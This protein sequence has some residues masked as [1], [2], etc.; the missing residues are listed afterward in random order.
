MSTN[1]KH[2][3][4]LLRQQE[5]YKKDVLEL[6]NIQ[7]PKVAFHYNC[8][9]GIVSAS[10]FKAIFSQLELVFIPLDYSIINDPE[11]L[12]LL[13]KTDWYA[14]L[15]LTPFNTNKLEL[16]VDHHISNIGKC[17]NANSIIF[18]SG[19]PSAAYLLSLMYGAKL[20]NHLLELARITEITDTASYAIPSPID[21]NDDFSSYSWDDKVWLLADV[22]KTIF[23]I[24]EHRNLIN[25]LVEYGLFGVW[26]E[27]FLSKVKDLRNERKRSMDIV[28]QTEIKDF[29]ILIDSPHNYDLHFIGSQLMYK[30]VKGSAY[31]SV[32]PDNVKISLRL[33]KTLSDEEID[34]YRVDELAKTLN[35]GGHKGASGGQMVSLDETIE[36]IHSWAKI[37][38]FSVIIVDLREN[39]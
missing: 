28:N 5:T 26:N 14:I 15:D 3:E 2:L 1:T 32:Y 10:L 29:I 7:Q 13:S 38:N 24:E 9:D 30:G 17:I 35:G 23:T 33:S 25:L 39:S 12:P 37:K 34:H 31:L 11:I 6:L 20:S 18:I 36:R 8:A 16:F 27:Y 19:A 4:D 22:C 21:F